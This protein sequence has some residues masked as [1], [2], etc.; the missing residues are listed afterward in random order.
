[1]WAENLTAVSNSIKF[2]QYLHT[3][4]L[5]ACYCMWGIINLREKIDI[6]ENISRP[7]I[8]CCYSELVM[9]LRSSGWVVLWFSF[10]YG[11]PCHRLDN[12][13]II[14]SGREF[15]KQNHTIL[16]LQPRP[17]VIA[18]NMQNRYLWKVGFEKSQAIRSFD[19][20]YSNIL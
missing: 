3:L 18:I 16:S 19:S 2:H 15:Q 9:G 8:V 6:F 12:V 10:Q 17:W 20:R 5:L 1:M 7:K 4:N 14:S 11:L 13:I